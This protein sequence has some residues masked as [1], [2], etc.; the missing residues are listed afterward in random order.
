[1]VDLG[2]GIWLGVQSYTFRNFDLEPALKRIK[3]LGIKHAEFYSKHIRGS[4][5]EKLKSI[6]AL[7]RNTK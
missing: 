1:M 3:E 5:P 7:C 2:A 6:L 4:K